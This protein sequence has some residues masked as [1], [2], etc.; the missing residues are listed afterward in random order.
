MEDEIID[1]RDMQQKFIIIGESHLFES[2]WD[3]R[4]YR[5]LDNTSITIDKALGIATA[6]ARA[7]CNSYC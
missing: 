2:G 3:M 7:N 5:K 4:H 6:L 1:E